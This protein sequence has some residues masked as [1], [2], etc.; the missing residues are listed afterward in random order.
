MR[1]RTEGVVYLLGVVA[2]GLGYYPLKSVLPP[3]LFIALALVYL[4]LLRLLGRAIAK[5]LNRAD[6]VS[7]WTRGR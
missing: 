7:E 1:L 2:L 4:V 6:D 3:I 5:R